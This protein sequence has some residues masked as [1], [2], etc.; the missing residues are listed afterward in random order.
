MAANPM[1]HSRTKHIEI[2]L[3]FVRD[4]VLKGNLQVNHI[5]AAYQKIDTLAKSLSKKNFMKF[6][7][8]L[9]IKENQASL[10]LRSSDSP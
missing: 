2:D 7:S 1:L 6:R 10:Q 9:G 3:H 8:E 5:P 4:Q